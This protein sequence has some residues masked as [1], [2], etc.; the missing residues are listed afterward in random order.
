VD[1]LSIRRG[2]WLFLQT[3][4]ETRYHGDERIRRNER[5][6]Q[7]AIGSDPLGLVLVEWIERTDQQNHRNVP[8]AGILLDEFADLVAIAH[9]HENISQDNVGVNFA[10]LSHGGFTITDCDDADA[11]VFQGQRYHLLDVTV[12]VRNEDCGHVTLRVNAQ[13]HNSWLS[14]NT[15]W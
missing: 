2:G 9:G 12:V 14:C 8:E 1:L 6:F 3:A 11:L 13:R 4:D 5:L 10:K 7:H 15:Y